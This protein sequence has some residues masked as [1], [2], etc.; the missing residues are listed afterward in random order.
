MVGVA[1]STS[2]QTETH[3]LAL[4]ATKGRLGFGGMGVASLLM[5]SPT[6]ACGSLER[7]RHAP[8][9]SKKL[10]E[11][12]GADFDR[13]FVRALVTLNYDVMS[14]FEQAAADLKDPDVRELAAVELPV[15]RGHR[16]TALDL[17]R[18]LD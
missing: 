1:A 7:H 18:T 13:E 9:R 16:N 2:E 4:A 14:L 5:D 17:K 15:L 12:S 6:P 3:S 11:K 8:S 10:I